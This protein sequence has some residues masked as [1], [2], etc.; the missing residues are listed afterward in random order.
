MLVLSLNK[1]QREK[2]IS[3]KELIYIN[4]AGKF[5]EKLPEKLPEKVSTGTVY[6][7]MST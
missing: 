4:S 3:W 1:W 5:P 2:W 6:L 7:T